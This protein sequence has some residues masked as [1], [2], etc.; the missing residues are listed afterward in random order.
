MVPMSELRSTPTPM[1]PLL[2]FKGMTPS[3]KGCS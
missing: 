3:T 1:N 2:F